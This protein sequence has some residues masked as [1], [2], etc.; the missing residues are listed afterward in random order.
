MAHVADVVAIGVLFFGAAVWVGGFVAMVVVS[1]V[2]TRALRPAEK[3][4]FFRLLGRVYGVVA[5]VALVLALAGGG[6]LLRHRPWNATTTAAVVVAAALVAA[7]AVGVRQAR[8]M[9]RLRRSAVDSPDDAGL[10][11]RVVTQARGAVVLRTLIGAITVV[12]VVLA[13][14]LVAS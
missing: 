14:V 7:T 10:A 3:I 4:A 2:A 5:T 6:A 13:L 8:A 12:L 11:A 1:R 9:T